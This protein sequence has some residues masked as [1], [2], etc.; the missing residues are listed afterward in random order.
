MSSDVDLLSRA[1][2]GDRAAFATLYDRHIRPVYW[3]AYA[4]VRAHEVAEDVTQEAFVTMWRRIRDIEC[5]D[6]SVLPWLL[7]TTKFVGYNTARREQRRAHDGIRDDLASSGSTELEAEAR[8]VHAEIAK[9][10]GNLSA[11]DQQL[12]ALCVEGGAS[13]HEAARE[14][15]VSHGA[16]RNRLHRV[17]AAL[18]ADL[19]SIRGT[20]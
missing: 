14:L 8:M 5:V 10:V 13:Y 11:L 12:Y 3:Q 6:D 2:R 20:A 19:R 18:R 9:A 4:V 15:G 17:R 7:V 16:V 1:Q